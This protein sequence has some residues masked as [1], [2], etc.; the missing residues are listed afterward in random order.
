MEGKGRQRRS[1]RRAIRRSPGF[2]SLV[3]IALLL[4]AY[5]AVLEYSRPHV[6]GDKLRL[7]TF[8]SYVREGR[9]QNA[10]IL[11][12]DGIVR[13]TYVRGGTASA[14]AGPAPRLDS[15]DELP[16]PAGPRPHV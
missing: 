16:A 10:R 15:M 14:P 2:W 4:A 13:G 1:F 7:D 9:I 6:S 12:S 3:A 5:L 11:D 8:V